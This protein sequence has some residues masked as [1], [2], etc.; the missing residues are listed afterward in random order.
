MTTEYWLVLITAAFYAG[1]LAGPLICR[2]VA[3]KPDRDSPR[4]LGDWG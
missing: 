3:G 2:L 4:L 1:I